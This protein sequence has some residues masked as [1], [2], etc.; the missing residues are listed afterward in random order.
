MATKKKIEQVTIVKEP[1]ESE[2]A[3]A[4]IGVVACIVAT[5]F[6]MCV[7]VWTVAKTWTYDKD[8]AAIEAK[9]QWAASTV[10]MLRG[11]V[12]FNSASES[13]RITNL[14]KK[15]CESKPC[16]PAVDS[17]LNFNNSV[18]TWDYGNEYTCIG[19]KCN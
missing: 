1:D 15:L 9:A 4:V 12:N 16:P 19:G 17:Y 6:V 10:S 18:Y 8:L 5:A 14:E 3:F 11:D 2:D 7:L 13:Q